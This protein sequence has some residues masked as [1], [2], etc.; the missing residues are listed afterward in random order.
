MRRGEACFR[1]YAVSQV[2]FEDHWNKFDFVLVLLSM[3]S[4]VSNQIRYT[5]GIGQEYNT[6][7]D[8]FNLMRVIRL[9]KNIN[10]WKVIL[11]L[12]IRIMPAMM[13]V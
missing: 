10:K 12:F 4:F 8:I 7:L 1:G 3:P 13:R 2:Y 6:Y 9:L 11:T 5:S